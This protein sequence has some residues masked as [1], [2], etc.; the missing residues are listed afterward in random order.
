[1]LWAVAAACIADASLYATVKGIQTDFGYSLPA[2]DGWQRQPEFAVAVNTVYM[3]AP[4]LKS[5][6][7]LEYDHGL[8]ELI[9]CT[10]A[11]CSVGI[12]QLEAAPDSNT[13]YSEVLSAILTSYGVN[14][15]STQTKLEPIDFAALGVQSRACRVDADCGADAARPTCCD[16][17]ETVPGLCCSTTQVNLHDAAVS[18][19]LVII[20]LTGA[21]LL[22]I[23]WTFTYCRRL[24]NIEDT[25]P[26][27]GVAGQ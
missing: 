12:E 22:A 8:N 2:T 13:I 18:P 10:A 7:P 9:K 15:A 17:S 5:P 11:Y 19:A 20:F 4:T 23:Y 1:M 27:L 21:G 16:A 3:Y 14:P 6:P 25:L 24:H 26:R